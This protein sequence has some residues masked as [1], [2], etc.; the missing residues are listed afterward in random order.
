MVIGETFFSFGVEVLLTYLQ[1]T[2]RFFNMII[3]SRLL[4]WPNWLGFESRHNEWTIF[5]LTSLLS[6]KLF[7]FFLGN[8]QLFKDATWFWF[9]KLLLFLIVGQDWFFWLMSKLSSNISLEA[10][11]VN[12]VFVTNTEHCAVVIGAE[13]YT[14]NWISMT[15]KGLEE[16]WHCLLCFIV[17]H[18]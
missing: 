8:P 18:L 15:Y 12:S 1:I 4:F 16:I 6:L 3:T 7:G 5:Q 13:H 14:P 2:N 11:K 10:P 9:L 17:P